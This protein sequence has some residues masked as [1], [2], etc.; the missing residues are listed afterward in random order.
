MDGVS[1]ERMARLFPPKAVEAGT[2][3]VTPGG[4]KPL[5]SVKEEQTP[6]V[7]LTAE[8]RAEKLQELA[9]LKAWRAVD[10][11]SDDDIKIDRLQKELGI[12]D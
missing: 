6:V 1:P 10:R 9:G 8:Q 4:E 12:I 7:P 5:A 11:V 2:P 3:V